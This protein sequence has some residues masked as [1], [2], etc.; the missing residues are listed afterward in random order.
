[1]NCSVQVKP[2]YASRGEQV[3]ILEKREMHCHPDG[4]K[5]GRM[6]NGDERNFLR[7]GEKP[8]VQ[9]LQYYRRTR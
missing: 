8:C 3:F 6:L 2:R 1:M 4:L 5:P 7:L 9:L